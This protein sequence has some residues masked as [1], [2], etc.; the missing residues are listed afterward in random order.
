MNFGYLHREVSKC[1]SFFGVGKVEVV[2]G[3]ATA[4]QDSLAL[5]ELVLSL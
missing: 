2:G 3:T 4:C 5:S 1:S